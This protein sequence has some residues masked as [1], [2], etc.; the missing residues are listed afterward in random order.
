MHIIKFWSLFEEKKR[1]STPTRYSILSDPRLSQLFALSSQLEALADSCEVAATHSVS[2]EDIDTHSKNMHP[3]PT[4]PPIP[5]KPLGMTPILNQIGPKNNGNSQD[6]NDGHSALNGNPLP[7]PKL[8]PRK[9]VSNDNNDSSYSMETPNSSQIRYHRLIESYNSTESRDGVEECNY[10]LDNSVLHD[11]SNEKFHISQ[12][13]TKSSMYSTQPATLNVASQPH[14]RFSTVSY[15]SRMSTS[16]GNDRVHN[17]EDEIVDGGFSTGNEL[18]MSGTNSAHSVLS[19][20]CNLSPQYSHVQD[21]V[22]D[23]KSYKIPRDSC[24][25]NIAIMNS[26]ASEFEIIMANELGY[27]PYSS[28]I[29]ESVDGIA[30]PPDEFV[31]AESGRY[32][33]SNNADFGDDAQYGYEQYENSTSFPV[34]RPP[35][36]GRSDETDSSTEKESE[37]GDK[38]HA[39]FR[40]GENAVSRERTKV[41]REDVTCWQTRCVELEFALQKFRDQAQTIRELLREKVSSFLFTYTF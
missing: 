14:L 24:E 40:K 33:W 11:S 7:I 38:N 15:D 27:H 34:L 16:S 5:P 36:I 12:D 30:R 17:I 10:I 31:N 3:S 26:S 37:H 32:R 2:R 28:D 9:V 6:L 1:K 18:D 25:E 22:I 20:N 21:L 35:P 4:P 41:K 29:K 39:S 13:A 19:A 23:T 8:P